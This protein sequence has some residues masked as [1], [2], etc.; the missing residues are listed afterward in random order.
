MIKLI[1]TDVDGTLVKD[2]T[3]L[4]D[5]EYMTVVSR[6]VDQGIHFVVCSGRQFSSEQKLFAPI[7]DRLLYI[8]DGGTVVRTPEKILKTYPMERHS[9]NPCAAW[10]TTNFRPATALPPPR[11]TASPKMPEAACFTGS[12]TPTASMS[13]KYR[14]YRR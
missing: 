12:A 4:I 6:L 10:Y 7:K 2:G 11:T 1:A 14:I 3:L 8:S 5:P 9:G 13:A